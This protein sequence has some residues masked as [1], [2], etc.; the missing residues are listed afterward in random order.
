MNKV[1]TTSDREILKQGMKLC[2]SAIH[3]FEARFHY[4]LTDKEERCALE[5]MEFLQDSLHDLGK[6]NLP[7]GWSLKKIIDDVVTISITRN[8]DGAWCGGGIK[9]EAGASGLRYEFL[10]SLMGEPK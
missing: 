3:Q 2:L 7:D 4:Q 9:G 5:A 10:E 6:M 8:E 1:W